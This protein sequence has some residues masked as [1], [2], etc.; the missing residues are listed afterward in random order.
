MEEWRSID[1]S[2]GNFEMILVTGEKLWG[3]FPIQSEESVFGKNTAGFLSW[4]K[5]AG[6][7]NSAKS[8]NSVSSD[9]VR[10]FIRPIPFVSIKSLRPSETELAGMSLVGNKP[11]PNG[12]QISIENHG[13]PGFVKL[14]YQVPGNPKSFEIGELEI[15]NGEI[16]LPLKLAFVSYA[17]EDQSEVEEIT[18]KLNDH[19][20]L[21]WFDEKEIFPGDH[22]QSKIEVAIEKSE[23]VMVFFSSKTMNRSGYKNKEIHYILDQAKYRPLGSRYIIPVLLDDCEPPREF[24][25]LHWLSHGK[26]GWLEKL[27]EVLK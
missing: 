16:E 11:I 24:K 4:D 25:E 13:K 7:Y 19:G 26:N 14:T 3:S 15:K 2:I 8:P 20:V 9:T 17:R 22:W 23:Y 6:F 5:H 12:L 21:T 18:R 27:L 10:E 1:R